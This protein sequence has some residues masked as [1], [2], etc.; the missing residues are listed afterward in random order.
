MADNDYALG[1]IVE[2]LSGTPWW[3][4]MVVF[5]TEDDAQGG[6][7]HIDSHRSIFMALG[8]H[9]KR[10]YLSR[11]NASFPGLLKTIFRTLRLGPLN[12]FDAWATDLADVYTAQPDYA[13]YTLLPVNA[14]LFDPAKAKDPLDP[15]PSEKM[16]D[17]NVLRE[18]HKRPAK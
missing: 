17:P 3:R 12:L 6:V 18:Q 7:D 13:P 10:G 5:V 1:R 8:P 9:V 15:A 4:N 11:H 16:D 14:E 2:F